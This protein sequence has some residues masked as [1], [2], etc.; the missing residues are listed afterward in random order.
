MEI[1][2]YSKISLR[3]FLKARKQRKANN[4]AK[5]RFEYANAARI[6]KPY[7][8]QL[9]TQTIKKEKELVIEELKT[10]QTLDLKKAANS[11]YNKQLRIIQCVLD[12]L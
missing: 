4:T 1:W 3:N 8:L 7:M 2:T 10:T 11:K 5:T 6:I 9:K 12:D